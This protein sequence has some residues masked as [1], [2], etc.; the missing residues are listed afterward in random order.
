MIIIK[1][2]Y[3]WGIRDLKYDK[4]VLKR[5][6]MRDETLTKATQKP[7]YD[8]TL[9]ATTQEQFDLLMQTFNKDIETDRKKKN[10]QEVN[11]NFYEYSE[12]K[13][14]TYIEYVMGFLSE[15]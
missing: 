2:E 10:F 14:E 7:L 4:W 11:A 13:G 8:E 6:V 3:P 15:K 12:H 5:K 9:T 1:E